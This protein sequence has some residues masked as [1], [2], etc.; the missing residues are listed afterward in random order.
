MKERVLITGAS[1]FVGYHLV[2]EALNKNLEVFVAVRKSSKIE[3]LKHLD[4][5]YTSLEFD[6]PS[7]LNKE[8]EENV[9]TLKN[10]TIS[11][12]MGL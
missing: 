8:L 6:N 5:K 7:A 1:G 11:E 2:T 12:L 3:H 9:A 4:I 10:S